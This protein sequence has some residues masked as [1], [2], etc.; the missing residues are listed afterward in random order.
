MLLQILISTCIKS[1]LG[2]WSFTS[3]GL[4]C[5][6]CSIDDKRNTTIHR[7]HHLVSY[8]YHSNT[9]LLV[10]SND[11]S[12]MI[13]NTTNSTTTT[14][15]QTM[16]PSCSV[17]NPSHLLVCHHLLWWTILNGEKGRRKTS[18][19]RRS[20]SYGKCGQSK[21]GKLLMN[22]EE[23]TL[24]LQYLTKP[25]QDLPIFIFQVWTP[26]ERRCGSQQVSSPWLH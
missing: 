24:Q 20:Y 8:M 7:S 9:T 23:L 10:T 22:S 17:Y 25:L 18:F 5:T 14:Q 11:N 26:I 3:A 1:C 4:S 2:I 19:W 13:C 21:T 12:V 15:S 6:H 16:L